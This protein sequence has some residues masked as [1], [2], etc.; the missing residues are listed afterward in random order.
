MASNTTNVQT[1]LGMLVDKK[2][3]YPRI[4]LRYPYLVCKNRMVSNYTYSI[5]SKIQSPSSSLGCQGN[6]TFVDH[7]CFLC[8][9]FLMLSRQ[10]NSAL[11]SP[12]GKGLTSWLLLVMFIVFC[13]F[14][15]WYPGSGV[16]LDCMIS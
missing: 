16:I 3:F 10:S 12:A 5:Y 2:N 1:T 11:W 6:T 4:K 7:L 13:Y 14:P 15:V 9:V 8:L